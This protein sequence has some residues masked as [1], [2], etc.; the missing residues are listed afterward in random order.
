MSRQTKERD[1]ATSED[2]AESPAS[3]VRSPAPRALRMLRRVPLVRLI[4]LVFF[5]LIVWGWLAGSIPGS[6]GIYFLVLFGLAALW[7]L[8]RLE[9]RR[10]Q[11]VPPCQLGPM[12][13]FLETLRR[14][15]ADEDPLPSRGS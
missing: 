1:P 13:R 7:H 10:A 12:L 11:S 4:Q 14:Y 9:V 5:E 8:V 2:R 3:S 15:V 6:V